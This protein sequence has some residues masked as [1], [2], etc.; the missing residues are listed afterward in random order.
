MTPSDLVPTLSTCKRLAALFE[1]REWETLAFWF[2]PEG[3]EPS[4]LVCFGEA[5]PYEPG[6][7]CRWYNAPTLEE[8][9]TL[10]GCACYELYEEDGLWLCFAWLLTKG[11]ARPEAAARNLIKQLENGA[12]PTECLERLSQTTGLTEKQDG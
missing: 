1:D 2:V 9:L 11:E 10:I 5:L 7:L 6:D 3:E 8:L 12:D 4:A